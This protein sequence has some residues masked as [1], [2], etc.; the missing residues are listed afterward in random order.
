MKS[1]KVA[2]G[3]GVLNL[4]HGLFHLLQAF[5]S[6]LLVHHSHEHSSI[7]MSVVWAAVGVVSLAI[8]IRDYKHHNKCK[9]T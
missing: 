7:W 9:Q 5:Q 4:V 3:V 2:I 6:I 8:G 1:F